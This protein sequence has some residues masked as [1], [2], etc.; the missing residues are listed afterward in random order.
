MFK[1]L[2]APLTHTLYPPTC[3][4][5]Q[6]A[7]STGRDLCEGCR[8]ALPRIAHPCPCCGLPQ[9][10]GHVTTACGTCQTRPPHYDRILASFAYAHPLDALLQRFKYQHKLAVGRV[11]GEL[12][13]ETLT[14]NLAQPDALLPVPL[15]ADALAERGFNQATELAQTIG[16]ALG[17]PVLLDLCTR[18]TATQRQSR[19]N[20]AARQR[21]LQHAFQLAYPPRYTHIAIVDDVVTTGTTVNELAQLLKSAGVARVDVWCLAR[22]TKAT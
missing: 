13:R 4:L 9:H 14:A 18:R 6:A 8:V 7:S 10:S 5:C 15:H 2:L 22:A 20:A 16:A 19:L 17:L 21:N 3:V 1:A 12:F 11:L